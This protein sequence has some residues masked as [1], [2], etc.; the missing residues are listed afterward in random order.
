MREVHDGAGTFGVVGVEHDV[1]VVER[2]LGRFGDD[3]GLL[4]L[5][6]TFERVAHAEQSCGDHGARTTA[7]ELVDR[8]FPVLRVGVDDLAVGLVLCSVGII[9][10]ALTLGPFAA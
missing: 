7:P 10:H 4:A 8:P 1:D 9:D 2:G 3:G 5:G 6:S